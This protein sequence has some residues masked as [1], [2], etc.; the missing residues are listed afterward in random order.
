GNI[1]SDWRSS[2][3]RK[4][5]RIMFRLAHFFLFVCL[6]AITYAQTTSPSSTL[7]LVY[8]V[9]G[10]TLTTY[11]IDPETLQST[12]VGTTNLPESVVIGLIPSP[13][14]HILYY[15][16]YQNLAQEGEMLY[17]YKTNSL[18]VPDGQPIQT[19]HAKGL[20]SYLV[21]PTGKFFYLV[22]QGAP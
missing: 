22:Y 7:Q 2:A 12:P 21:D 10:S 1:S 15:S 17:V 13:D 20:F 14:G 8:V 11:N 16:A 5:R 3:L 19:L 6:A 18:G 4:W 9:D